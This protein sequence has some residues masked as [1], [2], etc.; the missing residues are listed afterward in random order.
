MKEISVNEWLRLKESFPEA[1]LIDVREPQEYREVN[2]GGELIPLN[3]LPE[4]ISGM[5]PDSKYI[6]MCRSGQRSANAARYME[7]VGFSDVSNL[8]GGILAYLAEYN[9]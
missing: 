3:T 2:I 4:A 6:V 8:Q 9:P 1:R 5:D 7:Q